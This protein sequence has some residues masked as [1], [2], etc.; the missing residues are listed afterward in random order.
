MHLVYSAWE[1]NKGDVPL[2]YAVLFARLLIGGLFVY[3]SIYKVFNP[4]DFS[5]A[6]RDYGLLPVAWSNFVAVT[7]PW[8]ELTAGALLIVGVRTR[9]SAL[10][11]TSLPAVFFGA[12][13]YA[14]SIG[15]DIDCGCF[16]S[17]QDSG[18]KITLLTLCRDFSL[19]LVSF[20]IL[21]RNKGDSGLPGPSRY[22]AQSAG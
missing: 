2:K 11:T 6:V 13:A 3:A 19:L 21:L 5:Q 7:L 18:G 12:V 1:T 15:L 9:P 14:Y 8:I 17:A 10:V 4:A 20:L 22:T 16:S